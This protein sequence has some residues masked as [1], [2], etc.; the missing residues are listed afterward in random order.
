MCQCPITE[1]PKEPCLFIKIMATGM[2][3]IM[4][5]NQHPNVRNKTIKEKCC[6]KLQIR[7]NGHSNLKR[8]SNFLLSLNCADDNK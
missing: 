8:C 6:H 3:E 2:S 7:F 1:M 5:F 4:C